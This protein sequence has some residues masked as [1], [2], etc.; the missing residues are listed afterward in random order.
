M[1]DNYSYNINML[2]QS[3]FENVE[4]MQYESFEGE[5]VYQADSELEPDINQEDCW[6]VISSFFHDK[7][8]VR[9]QLDS[10]D[11]FVQNTMQEIVDEN[12]NLVLQTVAGNQ[13][14]EGDKAKRY[15]IRFGQVYLSKPTMTEADGS[16]Q[17]M[18]PQEARLRN[19]TYAAPLY[20]NMKEETMI[21]DPRAPENRGKATL[22][23]MFDEDDLKYDPEESSYDKVFVGK[24]PVM[25]KSTFCVLHGLD[26]KSLYALNECPYD[27]G[28]YFIIN[29]SEKVLIAQERMASNTVYVFAKS[30]PSPYSFTAEIKSAIEKGSKLIS[31]LMIKLLAKT[32]EKGATGQ[33]IQATMPYI[34]KDVPV[35]IA[36]RALGAVSDQDFLQ[37]VCYDHSDTQMLEA[38]KPC[39]EE[40]FAVQS[41]EVAADWIGRRGT[42]T[43]A[44]RDKRIKYAKDILQKE[45]LPHVSTE[46]GCEKRKAFFL[47]YMVHRL[48]LA[49][50]GRRELDDRDHYGK[51][52]MDLAGPLLASLFRMLFK[53]LTK[54]VSAY[55]RK[56]IDGNREFNLNLAIKA[57]TITNGL[58]YSLATGN[59]GDQKKAMQSRAGVS[60]VLNRYTFASTLSHLRRCNTPM[61]RDGKI[62]KPRQLHNTHWG[63]VC[64]SETPEGQ[65]CGLVKNLSLMSYISVGSASKPIIDFLEEYG[66]INLNQQFDPANIRDNAKVFVNGKWVGISSSPEQLSYTLKGL[67]RTVDVSPEVSVVRD[68]REKELRIYTD[69]GRVCRPLFIVESARLKIT[70]G[71][72]QK[73]DVYKMKNRQAGQ[74]EESDDD[75]FDD[76]ENID[77]DMEEEDIDNP[78]QSS[79]RRRKKKKSS[80]GWQELIS[81]SVVEYI[82]A[83][84][85]ETVMICMTPEDLASSRVF[86]ETGEVKQE[87]AHERDIAARVKTDTNLK[88]YTWTHCEIHPSMILGIC[89]S[90]IP[91]PDHNQSPRNTY[92]SAMGKQAMGIYVTNYQ[93]RMDTLANILYYPQKPVVTTRAME[94]LRFRELPAGQNAIVAIL[95]YSG[96]NQE[97]SVIMNQSSI[98][99]GL[100][101][102]IFYRSYMDQ[103]KKVG[104]LTIEE[105]EKPTKE[106]TLRLKH[107]TYEKLEDD[108]LI[109]PGTRVS[110][111]DIIIGKVTPISN[112]TLELGQRQTTHVQ[113]DASTP[114]RSTETGIVDQV[115]VTTNAEGMKFVKV[116][117]RSTRVPQMGDKFA[118][119]HGQKGTI[120]ITYRQ[121]DMPFTA[122][123]IAPDLVINPH[124][125]PSRMTIGHLVECLLGKVS[126]LTGQEGD[127]TPFT[128]VTVEAISQSLRLQGYQSRGFEV[129]YN[130]HT[131]RKLAAQVF[132]GPTYYQRLKHM[133]DDKI[134]SRARGPVQILTRQP[135][136]GRSRDGGLRF[137][138]ME[139]DCMISHGTAMFLKERLFDAS[140]AYRVH[141]CD[142][143]GL[144][145]IANLKK[146]TF[147][148]KACKNTTQISQIHI[149][150]ACKLLFQELMA[151]NISPRLF[152]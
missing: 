56:C 32:A 99:R 90:I 55:L 119:R 107:G 34:K 140:D 46:Y 30:P 130:G 108:G 122:E 49:A 94:F 45:L 133:V 103:E 145:A 126:T 59:W 41:M 91:F 110:G 11:E 72:I 12:K 111:D 89:A 52:R 125:I 79:R 143:C 8:L 101:R 75:L 27:Q 50:L 151:M 95:C 73:L 81:N 132:L 148:C 142:I 149:P 93:L 144:M 97:D 17:A 23:E 138:E 64:P 10:F 150:Y 80:F 118:S 54:D 128:D 62:A 115:M 37:Y 69:A 33:S 36:F 87:K 120:G 7:G 28:G 109:A 96:Y 114:M 67:R 83:E 152:T 18:F 14:G 2:D 124:A 15:Y 84:E 117:V 16:V 40:A 29:G 100:F 78:E 74:V 63:M 76:D 106:T 21:A 19:L 129:M 5:E 60:Q 26:D 25:L 85:E 105:F 22:N 146:N 6:T 121:E 47:G 131:G 1:E 43:G 13:G 92:Q 104:M 71:L 116:R 127:A 139:R 135:V 57:Q 51:K 70:K 42:A 137:G 147:E 3:D 88:I 48:L 77:D 112:E 58:K 102:S 123:G 68:I 9:Q 35:V 113:R 61:G 82:D 134:H 66:M 141:V 4:Q 65:A 31:S 38:L 44:T 98:D 136:E 39:I 20:V 86:H 53:K 24:I